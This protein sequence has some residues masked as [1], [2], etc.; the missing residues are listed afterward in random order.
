V[1]NK[2]EAL[3]FLERVR[4]AI[5]CRHYSIRTEQAYIA[6][7]KRFILFHGKRHPKEMGEPEVSEFLTFLANEQN[8]AA[9]TQNQAL[10][11]L[12][13]T[14]KSVLK[15]PLEDIQG[16]V[17]AKKPSRLPVVFT[18]DE[19]RR[20]INQLEGV[21]WLLGCILYG[22]GLRL[23]E[24]LRLRVLDL[25]FDRCA[26]IVRNGKGGKDRVATLAEE[27]IVPLQQ[28]LESVRMI[29]NRDLALGYGRVYL[30]HALARKYPN[31]DKEWK[32]QYVFPAKC[33]SDDPRTGITRRHHIH[34]TSLQRAV[35][36]AVRNA[37]INK[38]AS[39]HTFRHSFATHLLERGMDIRTIQEQL[40]HAD[41][42]TT[43]IY[44]HLIERG[45]AAV[46]SPLAS[47]LQ[48]HK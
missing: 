20:V 3:P 25:D 30:P 1:N 15:R 45:G 28:H 19:V 33:R 7:V 32:W 11:A 42:R 8:V 47:T 12:V 22:S 23:L 13:F 37:G 40:G 41:V 39:C 14:Y 2:N 26:V 48:L 34:E 6:W 35:K 10:C 5:K 16:A 29:H 9:N 46:L 17:R 36:N 43:Q 27:L 4:A 44:T 18:Q 38:H 24:C 21:Y 31:T